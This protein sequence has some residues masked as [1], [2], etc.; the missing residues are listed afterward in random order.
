MDFLFFL[1]D[2]FVI[3]FVVKIPALM[4]QMKNPVD[5]EK[6]YLGTLCL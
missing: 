4:I 5:I 3:L 6:G 1:L 2:N